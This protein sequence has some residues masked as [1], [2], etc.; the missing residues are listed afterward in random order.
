M[1]KSMIKS[2]TRMESV[3]DLSTLRV[4]RHSPN[5]TITSDETLTNSS[6]NLKS[7]YFATSLL[8]QFS[9]EKIVEFKKIF[10]ININDEINDETT[11]LIVQTENDLLCG[12]TTKY[13][14]AISRKLWIISIIYIFKC[15][16]AKS[17]LDFTEFE[18][19]GDQV[20]GNHFGPSRA[21][22]SNSP[23]LVNYEV[24]R[25]ECLIH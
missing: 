8:N 7:Y 2:T 18:V 15:L 3:L 4:K 23:L 11:H 6:I 14:K 12:V 5:N 22:I 9:K 19:Q 21:R 25:L 1:N 20:F 16:E 13:L 24:N 10:E 17:I